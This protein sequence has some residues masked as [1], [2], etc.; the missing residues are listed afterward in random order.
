MG[1]ELSTAS[2]LGGLDAREQACLL[3]A[4]KRSFLNCPAMLQMGQNRKFRFVE[5]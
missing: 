1:S 2:I 3:P 5:I 4:R